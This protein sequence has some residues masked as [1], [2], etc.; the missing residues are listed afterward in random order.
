MDD[1]DAEDLVGQGG[2]VAAVQVSP[3]GAAASVAGGSESGAGAL[4]DQT[5][6]PRHKAPPLQIFQATRQ[7]DIQ[8]ISD[9]A[10]EFHAESRYAHIPFSDEKFVRAFSRAIAN[11]QDMLALY[12]QH[13]GK[14]VGLLSAGVGD[15]YLGQGGRMAT[16][17][18]MYVSGR[19]R[20]SF[21]GG[22][23]ALKLLRLVSEWA[24][25]QKADELHIHAT[26]GIDPERTD[27]L[28]K[29]LGFETYGGN[30]VARLG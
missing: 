26:S 24:K 30:Y 25:A 4:P 17:Y 10:R 15:Y 29:R 9:I 18:V 7:E 1:L 21:L 16:V 5:V 19:L 8:L 14:T 13:G 3:N 23:I 22:K 28:L 11:P 6:R 20:H 12:I 27:K 2:L